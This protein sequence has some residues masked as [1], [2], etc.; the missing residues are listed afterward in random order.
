MT[1]F[2]HISDYAKHLLTKT[3]FVDCYGRN[4]GLDYQTI[5]EL[6]KE[7]FPKARTTKRALRHILYYCLDRSVRMPARYRSR[8]ILAREYAKARLLRRNERGLGRR[9]DKIKEDVRQK[10]PEVEMPE[11]RLRSMAASLK[12]SGFP[13]PE[14]PNR[15]GDIT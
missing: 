7:E 10:F 6:I 4:V 8:K 12:R 14:R 13:L 5:L 2:K 15:K 9:I 3:D 1:K 11:E